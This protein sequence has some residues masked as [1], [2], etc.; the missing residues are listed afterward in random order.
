MQDPTPAKRSGDQQSNARL[1]AT[2]H[3]Y[4]VYLRRRVVQSGGEDREDVPPIYTVYDAYRGMTM[5]MSMGMGMSGGH[6]GGWWTFMRYDPVSDKPKV[7]RALLKRVAGYAW[8]YRWRILM[9][10]V[11]I[12]AISLLSTVP[13]LLYRQLIDVVIP[14]RDLAALSWLALAMVGV[15]LISGLFG[16]AQRY[17]SSQVGEGVIYD[18]RR[19]LYEHLQR[20]SLRFFTHTHT[21]ELMSRLNNDVVGAQRAVSGTIVDIVSNIITLVVTLAV[22]LSLEW[23]LTL[24]SIVVLPLFVLPARRVGIL[25]RDVVRKQLSLNAEMNAMMNETLNVSGALL[26]KIFGRADDENRRFAERASRVRDVGIRQALIGRWF[27]LALALAGAT[28]TAMIAWVGGYLVIADTGFTT[29]TIVAFIAY[30]AQLYGPIGSLTN[31]RVDFVTSMVSFERVFEVLDLPV[32]IQEKPDAIELHDVRGHVRFEDVSFAYPAAEG[33]PGQRVAALSEVQRIGQMPMAVLTLADR[34]RP[35]G[36][37]GSVREGTGGLPLPPAPVES[38]LLTAT[39]GQEEEEQPAD[40][41]EVRYA[42]RDVSFEVLPGQ[43]AALVGPS[44]AGKTT[45]TYLLPRLYDP[46][47]GRILIDGIDIRDVTL[48]SLSAQI[49][50]VTQETYL[51]HD[52]IRANLLYARPD[53]TEAQMI[54]AARAANIHDFIMSLPDKY[55]T[56]VGERGYRLSGGEKQRIA[57][58]RVL[59]KD[60]RILVLDEATSSLDSQ[61]EA[62]I[63]SAL[64]RVMQGRTSIVIAHRL[65]TILAADLILVMDKGQLVEQGTHPELL[66]K[67][68]LYAK[69]YRTQFRHALTTAR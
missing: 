59:L 8:P 12:V 36:S 61:S 69:L 56:I 33:A 37:G 39:D 5:G 45:I 4:I 20:M 57:I 23:R 48:E 68:G 29:G 27:F 64:E 9:M 35:E 11:T 52:T 62:L 63:Q 49:G 65:S 13:P 32:E 44:G 24:L 50:M 16:L 22:M 17:L 31:A 60:P 67:D 25:L 6:G 30:L 14:G 55:D 7:S 54:E 21:G 42:L 15:P 3:E 51:F 19:A 53:A 2:M 66:A 46:T 40:P 18:L 26:V 47:A 34:K 43:L 1:T 58:A 41:T 10:L 38:A 28:G